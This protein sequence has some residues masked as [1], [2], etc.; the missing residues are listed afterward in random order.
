MDKIANRLNPAFNEIFNKYK[1]SYYW[2]IYQGEWAT[3]VM[4][5]S[6]AAL[7]SIYPQLVRGAMSTFSSPDVMRFLGGKIF[8]GNF[9]GE[10]ISSYKKRPE[11][12]RVKHQVNVNSVKM[13][14]KKGS[15]LRIETTLND[16]RDFKVYKN[17]NNGVD[18]CEGKVQ[19]HIKIFLP[20]E[21]E[22]DGQYYKEKKSIQTFPM[23]NFWESRTLF[24]KRL[25]AAGGK[26]GGGFL[27]FFMA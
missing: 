23:K 7:A 1:I 18:S 19:L 12:V 26:N 20:K 17:K 16:V 24:I 15:G 11:G 9:K 8:N 10:V 21:Q 4:F 27:F 13:Y 14:D 22:V 2:T 25:L 5:K 6:S 3:D